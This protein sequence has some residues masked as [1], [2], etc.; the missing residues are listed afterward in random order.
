MPAESASA[1][2]VDT[3]EDVEREPDYRF[4]LANERTVLAWLRTSLAL[5]AAG[6]AVV[7]FVPLLGRPAVR[8]ATGLG[9]TVLSVVTA[10]AAVLRWRTVQRAMRRGRPLPG[11][12][13]VWVVAAG[14][15]AAGLV[16]CVMMLAG[17]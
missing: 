4:T 7:Q 15:A 17:P 14:L 11:S 13:A 12:V 9:F 16:V 10:I 1:A 6:V 5:M 8:E 3:R 2:A